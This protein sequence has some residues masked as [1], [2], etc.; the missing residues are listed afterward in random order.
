MTKKTMKNDQTGILEASPP[1][2]SMLRVWY[3]SYMN[4]IE[5]EERPGAQ[6]R[7]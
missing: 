7:G 2:S 3:R 6:S 1:I 5:Q 4:P